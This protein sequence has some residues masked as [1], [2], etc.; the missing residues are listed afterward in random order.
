ML[1]G[2][3]L[4]EHEIEQSLKVQLKDV[5]IKCYGNENSKAL[6]VGLV[7]TKSSGTESDKHDTSNR[8]GNDTTH[9]VDA[10]IKPVNN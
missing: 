9:S 5:Q 7:L 4:H 6:D 3:I 10:N 2:A 1:N 8:S